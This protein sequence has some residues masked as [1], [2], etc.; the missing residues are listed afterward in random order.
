MGSSSVVER[1]LS[2]HKVLGAISSTSIKKEKIEKT[3]GKVFSNNV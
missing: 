2:K 3:K 1:M